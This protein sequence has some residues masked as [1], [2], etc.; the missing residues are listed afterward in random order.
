MDIQIEKDPTLRDLVRIYQRRRSVVYGIM[1]TIGVLT[2]I[3]CLVCTRRYEATGLI[4]V[5]KQGMDGMGLEDLMGGASGGDSSPLSANIEIQ[6]QANILQSDTLALRTIE[7][8]GLEQNQDFRPHWNPLGWAFEL[9]SPKGV[10]DPSGVKLEDAPV[11]RSKALKV[12]S[13]NLKVKPVTGT[14][15]IEIDYLN[16]DP[17]VAAAVINTLTRNLSDYAYE[18]RF[19]ATNK[20]SQWLG[21]QLG[22][23]RKDSEDLQA[24][25]VNLQ[26][27]S[28]V[29]SLGTTDSTGREQAYSGVLD[30]LQ[31]ATTALTTATQNR[32]LK[33]A[34]S[35]AAET[36]DAEMLSGLA[37]NALPGASAG[38]ATALSLVQSLRQQQ[39]AE[40][41]TLKEAEVKYGPAYPKLS[42][43][44]GNLAGIQHSIDQE[45]GRIR[46]RAASD[47]QIATATEASARKAYENAKREADILNN[48]AIEYVI[49]RQEAEQ[50]RGLY[51]DLLKRLKEA[52]VLEGLK[53]SNITLIDPGRA[54]AKPKTP[55]VPLYMMT[56]LV[57]GWV[58]GCCGAFLVDNLDNKVIS[59][60][61]L[62]D[63]FK[64]S[65]LGVLPK[66]ELP[67]SQTD[68]SKRILAL[69]DPGS[70]YVEALR[71]IKTALLL[72]QTEAPP[73][74]ILVTSS[75]AGEGKSFC[76]LNLAIILAQGGRRTLII[77]TDLRRGTL[78]QRLGISHR[79]G[80]SDLLAGQQ[81]TPPI[82]AVPGIDN[83]HVLLAG[84]TPP[85]PT[86]LLESESMKNWLHKFRHEYDFVVLDSAPVLPVT[87]SVA[88][89]TLTDSTLLIVRSRVS[90]RPQAQR[91]YQLLRRDGQ[92]YVGLILNGMDVSD[93]SYYG[94][95]GYRRHGYRYS[96]EDNRVD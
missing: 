42:E 70:N 81:A 43:M 91:S 96:E 83:L 59:V 35:K 9:V 7:Q 40:Q 62:E 93:S 10:G 34:I 56:A 60:D 41:A 65:P 73:K 72:S 13:K 50:S 49:V 22:D 19:Q 58:L 6:T 17:K 84:A 37:G 39:A 76:S 94:Y 14:R 66:M 47:F 78:R 95:H 24:K 68:P 67:V 38:A 80:L 92:H 82:L 86:D 77:D 26:R 51:E 12:F 11:R 57:G 79:P 4:Q 89:N 1:T 75:I 48:K 71:S 27:E 63:L 69:A 2:I 54:P 46:G 90:E 55:N 33:G 29:Y 31:Q 85:N 16:P 23:L 64:L 21:D 74:T 61:D 30:R 88:L 52:G 87:D 18:T 36:G 20:A 45:I 5:Q 3:Y 8:L 28:G 15:I 53:S 32:I 44:R 25:V